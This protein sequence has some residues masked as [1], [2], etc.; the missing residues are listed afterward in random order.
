M[1]LDLQ[2][3]AHKSFLDSLASLK[4]AG[5]VDITAYCVD[6][7]DSSIWASILVVQVMY[8]TKL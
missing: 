8:G 4:V 7:F 6:F 5:I 2:P 1:Q 3:V